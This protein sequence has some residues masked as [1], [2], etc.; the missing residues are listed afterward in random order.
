MVSQIAADK[1]QQQVIYFAPHKIGWLNTQLAMDPVH[2]IQTLNDAQ[3]FTAGFQ[4]SKQVPCSAYNQYGFTGG[5]IYGTYFL[6][7]FFQ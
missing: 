3:P 6:Y 4:Q 7:T 5:I 1:T 2:A